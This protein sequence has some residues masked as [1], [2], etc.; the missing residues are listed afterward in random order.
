M[1]Q[2]IRS[3]VGSYR[4]YFYSVGQ[5][6]NI[7]SRWLSSPKIHG[8]VS[9]GWMKGFRCNETKKSLPVFMLTFYPPAATS[10]IQNTSEREALKTHHQR[11]KTAFE[12]A[13]EDVLVEVERMRCV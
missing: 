2:E 13:K 4:G 11:S 1:S 8:S 10:L 7:S 9:G 3:I 12:A 6:L 5:P